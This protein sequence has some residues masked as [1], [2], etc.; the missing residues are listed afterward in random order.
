MM[1]ENDFDIDGLIKKIKKYAQKN[2]SKS[3]YEHS[4]RTAEMCSK[5]CSLYNLDENLGY[6]EGIAHDMCKNLDSEKMIELSRKDRDPIT[7]IEMERPGLLHGRAAAVMLEED[8]DFHDKRIIEAVANHTFGKVSMG[9]Y[10]KI[11]FV[12]D[13]VEPGREHITPE[14]L[15]ELF[16][17]PLNRA[18]EKV[19]QENIDYLNQKGKKIAPESI[20][21]LDWLKSL[22]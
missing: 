6:L 5:L 13:K 8:F 15:K 4:V 18:C 20:R 3:R 16:K 1:T 22:F 7:E 2:V 12:A 9:D 14:Y 19:L 11:L 21:L 17:L 10:A